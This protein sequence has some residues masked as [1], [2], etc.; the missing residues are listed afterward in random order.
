M[1]KMKENIIENKEFNEYNYNENNKQYSVLKYILITV[2]SIILFIFIIKVFFPRLVIKINFDING[3]KLNGNG[4]F[5][6]SI[7]DSAGY[8]ENISFCL[9]E[10]KFYSEFE[11][12]DD[13]N[14]EVDMCDSS[15][16]FEYNHMNLSYKSDDKQSYCFYSSFYSSYNAYEKQ[17]LCNAAD[18]MAK[19]PY[20]I[21]FDELDK[22]NIDTSH[23]CNKN[24]K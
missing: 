3:Y 22:L 13:D 21:Y 6:K 8:K 2:V 12:F 14:F 5:T 4:C 11:S 24:E 1:C 10:R 17:A 20:E 7:Q 18:D 23:L 15:V 16:K 19:Y 9:S